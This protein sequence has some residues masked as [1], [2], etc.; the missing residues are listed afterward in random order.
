MNQ[1]KD[2]IV[3]AVGAGQTPGTTIGN[4]RAASLVY[5]RGGGTVVCVDRDLDSAK[6]TAEM[7]RAEGG[8]AT[9]VQADI[10][11]ESDIADLVARCVAE[12]GRID[13][14]HNNV[15]TSLAGGDTPIED[16]TADAFDSVTATNLRGMVM[17]CKHVLKVMC[18]QRSGAIV[19]ISST[20]AVLDYPNIAYK[21]SKAGVVALTENIAIRFA[22]YGIRANCILPGLMDTPMAIESRVGRDGATR[23]QVKASRSALVPLGTMGTA[24]D[25]AEAAAF[26]ASDKAAFITGVSLRV[27]G[28]QCLK[29]G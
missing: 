7:I 28:G 12:F 15:G 14:L 22:P 24:W 6:E 8:T 2:K 23:E 4:G 11:V 18:A 27:D 10:T 25:T 19:N 21:T 20:A 5:A 1:F 29:I 9:A 3:V 16:S 17:T 13:V 26:L